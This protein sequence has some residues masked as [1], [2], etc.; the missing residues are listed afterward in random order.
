M[1]QKIIQQ[2]LRDILDKNPSKDEI[3][4]E[5]LQIGVRAARR[6]LAYKSA[7][8]VYQITRRFLDDNAQIT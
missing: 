6:F 5:L 3:K 2:I 1:E 7:K 4:T 8:G